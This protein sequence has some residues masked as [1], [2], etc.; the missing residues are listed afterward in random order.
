MEKGVFK[1]SVMGGFKKEDVLSYIEESDRRYDEQARALDE[2]NHLLQ[3]EL[4]ESKK[5]FAKKDA[6]IAELSTRLEKALS[7]KKETEEGRASLQNELNVLRTDTAKKNLEIDSLHQ[8]LL[9]E[10]QKTADYEKRL[11]AMGGEADRQTQ[12]LRELESRLG[13]TAKTEDQIA[14]V[15]IEARVSADKMLEDARLSAKRA[16]EDSAESL[17]ALSRKIEPLC[18][19]LDE[20]REKLRD[21]CGLAD[22]TLGE[23]A[24]AA[25]SLTEQFAGAAAEDGQEQ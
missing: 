22:Q 19:A 10:R 23:T 24:D 15:M 12:T 18:G 2:K 21:F 3:R 13:K 25:K 1:T 9:G 5:D 17:H 11:S 20:L 6:L 16:A 7:E 14:R 8:D 4:D